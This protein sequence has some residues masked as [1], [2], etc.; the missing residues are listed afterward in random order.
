MVPRIILAPLATN[1]LSSSLASISAVPKCPPSTFVGTL[2]VRGVVAARDLPPVQNNGLGNLESVRQCQARFAGQTQR[3]TEV[4][5]TVDPIWPPGETMFMDVSLPL[6]QVTH[7]NESET[8]A[9]AA[10][11][12]MPTPTPE[13]LSRPIL[14]VALFHAQCRPI[15]KNILPK[16][17]SSLVTRMNRL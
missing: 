9:V 17:C 16:R 8:N 2:I 14:T 3:T 5:D 15:Q 6:A 7:R 1:G 10:A 4:F 13:P 12:A 11:A